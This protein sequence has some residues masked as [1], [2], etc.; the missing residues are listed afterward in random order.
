[1]FQ[2]EDQGYRAMKRCWRFTFLW[3]MLIPWMAFAQEGLRER[4]HHQ[5]SQ[6]MEMAYQGKDQALDVLIQKIDGQNDPEASYLL[7]DFFMHQPTR[8]RLNMPDYARAAYYYGRVITLAKGGK[9]R[10]WLPQAQYK[11]AMLLMQGKG[12]AQDQPRA[13]SLLKAA[14]D[15]GVLAAAREYADAR[16]RQAPK[17]LSAQQEAERWLRFAIRMGD[18]EAALRLARWYEKGILPKKTTTSVRN[19]V[20]LG[21]SSFEA[22][23]KQGES[24]ALLALGR[25]EEEG[26]YTPKNDKKALSYYREAIKAGSTDALLAAARL[27]IRMR[28]HPQDQQEATGYILKA[29]KQGNVQAALLLAATLDNDENEALVPP[30]EALLWLRRAA[31]VGHGGA[32]TMLAHHY[33]ARQRMDLAVPYFELLAKRGNLRLH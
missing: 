14:A 3:G 9:S 19:L 6:M 25:I 31:N 18:G 23:A 11:L 22:R 30:K 16:I 28:Q 10:E 7:A 33:A 26:K 2:M 21:L 29:A 13:T 17:D 27:L 32:I 12:I 4:L 8:Y 20:A 1:M 15:S 5:I 24:T